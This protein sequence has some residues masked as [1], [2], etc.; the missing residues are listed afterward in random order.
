M[1]SGAVSRGTAENGS[2]RELD[3]TASESNAW[4]LRGHGHFP[5]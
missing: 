1:E 2:E 3:C 4:T 5:G